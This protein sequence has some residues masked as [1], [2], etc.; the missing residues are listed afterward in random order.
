MT[1][2]VMTVRVKAEILRL[3]KRF[4]P[5]AESLHQGRFDDASIVYIYARIWLNVCLDPHWM[6]TPIGGFIAKAGRRRRRSSQEEDE[7]EEEEE[8]DDEFR[9][10]KRNSG[11][12]QLRKEDG[13]IIEHLGEMRTIATKYFSQLLKAEETTLEILN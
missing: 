4:N 9:P 6:W 11:I 8:Q 3:S 13:T 12:R 5:G 2:K 10:R 7:E 1:F